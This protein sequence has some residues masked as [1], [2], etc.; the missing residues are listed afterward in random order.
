MLP[1]ESASSLPLA[2]APTLHARGKSSGAYSVLEAE[3][4]RYERERKRRDVPRQR[5]HRERRQN[6]GQQRRAT[7]QVRK[8]NGELRKNNAKQNGRERRR[9]MEN[10]IDHRQIEGGT[11][12]LRRGMQF[13]Q[14]MGHQS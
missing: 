6:D 2:G 13:G 7:G 5:Y 11:R 8:A 14:V 10:E 1:L 3:R 12:K 4:R 9:D